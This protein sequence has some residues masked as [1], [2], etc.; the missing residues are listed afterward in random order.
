M[1]ESKGHSNSLAVHEDHFLGTVFDLICDAEVSENQHLI[2]VQFL[3]GALGV[4]PVVE[5]LLRQPHELAFLAALWLPVEREQVAKLQDAHPCEGYES[6]PLPIKKE[7]AI[8]RALSE[9][10]EL[11]VAA[12]WS[13]SSASS[14]ISRK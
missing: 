5:L 1:D 9:S 13:K 11:E 6:F 2:D 4:L 14:R 3:V 7:T 10:E 8:K 12:L